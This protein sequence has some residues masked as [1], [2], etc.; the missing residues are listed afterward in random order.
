MCMTYDFEGMVKESFF[1]NLNDKEN[2]IEKFQY[3]PTQVSIPK[4]CY[5]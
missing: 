1:N 2:T 4:K 5:S 3:N